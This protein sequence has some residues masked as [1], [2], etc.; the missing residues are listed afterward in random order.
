[1]EELIKIGEIIKIDTST[2]E[3]H[4][5]GETFS[6][7]KVLTLPEMIS[8]VDDVINNCFITDDEGKEMYMPELRIF[9][10]NNMILKYYTNIE[11]P[12]NVL[13][14]YM[15]TLYM[16]GLIREITSPEYIN[17][18]QFQSIM[19]SIDQKIDYRIKKNIHSFNDTFATLV[20]FII[21][22][23]NTFKSE[24][25]DIDKEFVQK[26]MEAVSEGAI[27]NDRAKALI[28]KSEDNG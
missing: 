2:S 12:D 13:E 23:V 19:M 5:N 24:Y 9:V 1:M 15:Y 10:I 25:G 18:I 4:Y 27:I 17:T 6:V 28:E 16:D 7:K 8:F 22:V 11:M 3:V 14:R 20:N 21:N 26:F